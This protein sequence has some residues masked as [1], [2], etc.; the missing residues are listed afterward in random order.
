MFHNF[1]RLFG[2]PG[3][4]KWDKDLIRKRKKENLK[5][6]DRY[7]Q[8]KEIEETEVY[9]LRKEPAIWLPIQNVPALL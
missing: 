5:G 8:G 4:Q 3:R 1:V 9:G 6:A 2:M 7:D